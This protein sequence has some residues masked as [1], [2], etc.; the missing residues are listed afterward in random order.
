MLTTKASL[1]VCLLARLFEIVVLAVLY[2]TVL[3]VAFVASTLTN[4]WISS[5]FLYCC[6]LMLTRLPLHDIIIEGNAVF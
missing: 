3:L 2:F 1:L 4:D 5:I 6:A